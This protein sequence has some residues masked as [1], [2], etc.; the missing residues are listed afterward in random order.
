MGVLDRIR[1][2]ATALNHLGTGSVHDP[3]RKPERP[4]GEL[5]GMKVEE[6]DERLDRQ[7]RQALGGCLL[8]CDGNNTALYRSFPYAEVPL[9]IGNIVIRTDVN[10]STPIP[11]PPPG[12]SYYNFFPDRCR[13]GEPWTT[14]IQFW[15]D[16]VCGKFGGN[17]VSGYVCNATAPCEGNVTRTFA[18]SS[19]RNTP[20]P[21]STQFVIAPTTTFA[22]MSVTPVVLLE[23]PGF[24]F[25]SPYPPSIGDNPAT[26]NNAIIGYTTGGAVSVV[27]L[28][29]VT[30]SIQK[31]LDAYAYHRKA[32]P[33]TV[34]KIKAAQAARVEKEAQAE[35]WV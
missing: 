35:T 8:A 19:I 3:L 10:N 26:S 22:S 17:E 24:A 25:P 7:R 30:K 34:D 20:T 33:T 31:C 5:L 23:S 21:S 15:L 6:A 1:A 12:H 18:T 13:S 32:H 28:L 14:S 9:P 11:R 16:R 4:L 2:A 27:L 29:C